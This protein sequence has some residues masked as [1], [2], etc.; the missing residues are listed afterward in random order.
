MALKFGTEVD[1]VKA[2]TLQTFKVKQSNLQLSKPTCAKQSINQS[3][4]QSL[5]VNLHGTNSIKI[6]NK[7]RVSR[8]NCTL[9]VFFV[10]CVQIR[11]L[12]YLLTYLHNNKHNW[13]RQSSEHPCVCRV[14]TSVSRGHSVCV[15]G[16]DVQLWTCYCSHRQQQ[17]SSIDNTTQYNSHFVYAKIQDRH[18]AVS[19][20]RAGPRYYAPVYKSRADV[21]GAL[22]SPFDQRRPGLQVEQDATLSFWPS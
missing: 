5:S 7:H 9:T 17:T 11:V 13:Q 3:N 20:Y 15:C 19:Y 22:L 10:R 2:N 8:S 21:V 16:H 4:N 18:G 1:K 12:T 14:N 6:Q